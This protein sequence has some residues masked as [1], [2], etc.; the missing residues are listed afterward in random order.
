MHLKPL[1][2]THH[3]NSSNSCQDFSFQ[4]HFHLF[5]ILPPLI[6]PLYHAREH[7]RLNNLPIQCVNRVPGVRINLR[8]MFLV[9]VLHMSTIEG[10]LGRIRQDL[11][12]GKL[13]A[14]V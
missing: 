3:Y 14:E 7:H 9:H 8:L 1:K 13:V 5:I 4:N 6:P 11:E 2:P 12:F 10:S